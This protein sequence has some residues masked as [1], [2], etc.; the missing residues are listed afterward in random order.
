MNIGVHISF[1]IS[2]FV[3][4][5]Y[6]PRSGIARSYGSFIFSF[7]RSLHTVFHSGCTNLHSHQ[8]WKR[9]PFFFFHIFTNISYLYFFFLMIAICQVRSDSSLWFWFGITLMI[10]NV[11]HLFMCLL[12]ICISLEISIQVFS[13]L[14][15]VLLLQ[16]ILNFMAASAAY[17]SFQSRNW[18]QAAAA[19]YTTAAAM[20]DPFLIHCSWPGIKR[21]PP[22]H[23]ES[24]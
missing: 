22:K 8:Q 7:L 12:T 24:L 9:V 3:S 2:V 17:W 18:I 21:L 20:P 23:S 1:L 16:Q 6:I 11:E 10:S 15:Q 4:F 5:G 13:L 19:T 14:N